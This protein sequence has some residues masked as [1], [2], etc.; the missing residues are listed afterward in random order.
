MKKVMLVALFPVLGCF[1]DM[2]TIDSTSIHAQKKAHYRKVAVID[3]AG[4]GGQ[5]V[6][7]IMTMNLLKAGYDVVE[8]DR[9][10]RLVTEQQIG[11]EGYKEMSDAEKAMRLGRIL[12]A[13][14]LLTGQL[15]NFTAP[16]YS[17]PGLFLLMFGISGENSILFTSARTEIAA[18]AIDARTGQIVWVALVNCTTKA[19]RGKHL[20]VMDFINKPCA[21]LVKAFRDPT[22]EGV[23]VVEKNG[24]PDLAGIYMGLMMT[25]R[26]TLKR[27]PHAALA[28]LE[29]E[30]KQFEGSKFA[31][32]FERM[33][34]RTRAALRKGR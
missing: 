25:W 24:E 30:E 5:A 32:Q 33:L 27:D 31:K 26:E 12:N 29:A 4:K 23:K 3:F 22:Y 9:I 21:E 20:G 34:K 1:D 13:D 15:V 8:R 7:D 16:T 28:M 19:G 11:V 6:A 17:K 18:R 14:V 2:L 10:A